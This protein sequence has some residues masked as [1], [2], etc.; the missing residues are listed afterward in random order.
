MSLEKENI[1]N[2]NEIAAFES[3]IM[4]T[5][6]QSILIDPYQCNQCENYFCNNCI[7]IWQKT[8]RTC[9]FKCPKFQLKEAKLIKQLLHKITFK[10][11]HKC[12]NDIPYK[13]YFKHIDDTCPSLTLE[14]KIQNLKSKMQDLFVELS[15]FKKVRYIL[16]GKNSFTTENQVLISKHKHPLVCINTKD[17]GGWICDICSKHGYSESYYCGLCDFDCCLQCQRKE[18]I[19]KSIEE[20]K[21]HIIGKKTKTKDCIIF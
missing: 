19:K 12:G 16:P 17:R 1:A 20:K 11:P 3:E 14:K 15:Q 5:I 10:C 4:C 6:C 2:L 7:N 13:E 21:K 8:S 9:P 18:E